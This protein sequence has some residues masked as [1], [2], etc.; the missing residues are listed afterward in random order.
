MRAPVQIEL[1]EP[2]QSIYHL[3]M[4]S[5]I[6]RHFFNANRSIEVDPE[7][8]S[9]IAQTRDMMNINPIDRTRAQFM[10]L[11]LQRISLEIN[12]KRARQ[13]QAFVV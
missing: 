1:N 7:L 11:E 9:Y 8:V 13:N 12:A 10:G 2:V 5:S 4:M 6:D 3:K